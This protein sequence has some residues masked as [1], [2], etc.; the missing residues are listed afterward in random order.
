[1]ERPANVFSA[2]TIRLVINVSTAKTDTLAT[3]SNLTAD[4]SK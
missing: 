2:C 3:P 1:M 4:V